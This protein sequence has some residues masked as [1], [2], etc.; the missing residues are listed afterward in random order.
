[1]E[2]LARAEE[3]LSSLKLLIHLYQEGLPL[4]GSSVSEEESHISTIS[5]VSNEKSGMS[6][7]TKESIKSIDETDKKLRISQEKRANKLKEKT[8]KSSSPKAEKESGSRKSPLKYNGPET[9]PNIKAN[10]SPEASGNSTLSA[11]SNSKGGVASSQAV[12][13]E[14]SSDNIIAQDD[15]LPPYN[16]DIDA[17]DSDEFN[18]RI[19][20]IANSN[21]SSPKTDNTLS[22][23]SKSAQ[24]TP[25]SN[26]SQNESHP[27]KNNSV[28]P[29]NDGSKGQ[30]DSIMEE[31]ESK[32]DLEALKAQLNLSSGSSEAAEDPKGTLM[33]VS[34]KAENLRPGHWSEI[35]EDSDSPAENGN[36]S[37]LHRLDIPV[38]EEE[39]D[40][41]LQLNSEGSSVINEPIVLEIPKGLSEEESNFSVEDL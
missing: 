16:P 31:E 32:A 5:Y 4:D 30:Q 8:S 27:S 11:Y 39:S 19:R 35:E 25:Q 17:L 18:E 2:H 38:D 23:P 7:S 40:F 14:F 33:N 24:A 41:V 29:K 12:G 15:H 9:K 1:M 22:S 13:G 6:P 36:S 34:P 20:R 28:T 26:K 10:Y 21:S 37:E 3:A